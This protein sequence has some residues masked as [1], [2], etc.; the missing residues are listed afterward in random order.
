M[1]YNEEN[2]VGKKIR[3]YPSDTYRKFG[4]IK[5]VD[6]LG[7]TIEIIESKCSSF[8]VGEEYFISH[9]EGFTFEFI[10]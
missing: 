10:R 9:S 4:V 8:D 1:K 3:L 2:Y 5:R 6:D 7:W